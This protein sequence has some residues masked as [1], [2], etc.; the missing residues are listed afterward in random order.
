MIELSA[1]RAQEVV[2]ALGAF[3][4]DRLELADVFSDQPWSEV[5]ELYND[6]GELAAFIEKADLDDLEIAALLEPHLA[7][8]IKRELGAKSVHITFKPQPKGV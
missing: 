4:A 7:E 6:F 1:K 3:L 8:M 2:A 5:F